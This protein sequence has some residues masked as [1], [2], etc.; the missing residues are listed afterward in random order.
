[1]A[2]ATAKIPLTDA[3]IEKLAKV[4]A[5][6]DLESIAYEYLNFKYPDVSAIN[7]GGGTGSG[8][9][10]RFNREVFKKWKNMCTEHDQVEVRFQCVQISKFP[11]I[12]GIIPKCC[13]SILLRNIGHSKDTQPSSRKVW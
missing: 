9:A 7:K 4:I 6:S 1:M 8:E 12:F 10:T 11:C 13:I 3:V 2:S 5:S